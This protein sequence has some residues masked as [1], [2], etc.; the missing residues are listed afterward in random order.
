MCTPSPI[1]LIYTGFVLDEAYARVLHVCIV[2][3]SGLLK[4]TNENVK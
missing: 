2:Y 4:S 3:T 1:L